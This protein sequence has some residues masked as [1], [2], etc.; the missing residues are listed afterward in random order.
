MDSDSDSCSIRIL[1]VCMGNICRSPMAEFMLK[2]MVSKDNLNKR[3]I[4]NSAAVTD[5]QI[6][7]DIAEGTKKELDRWL[8]PYKKRAAVKFKKEDYENYDY[9]IAM[10][11]TI[12]KGILKIIGKDSKHKVC[13]LLD[14]SNF[15]RD[16][17]DPAETN[18]FKRTYREIKEGCDFFYKYLISHE[19]TKKHTRLRSA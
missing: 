3:F 13:K 9:I 10:D 5:E 6:G 12:I 19:I 1:F 7:K 8:I 18:D 17:V 15:P 11:E 4:I 14:F 2:Y 16:I